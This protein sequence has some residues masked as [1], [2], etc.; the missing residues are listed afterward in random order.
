MTDYIK[1]A[2]ALADGWF[3]ETHGTNPS[4]NYIRSLSGYR[5][6][7]GSADEIID[8]LAAALVRQ[9]DALGYHYAVVTFSD[10]SCVEYWEGGTSEFVGFEEGKD[11]TMNT[12]KCIVDSGVL[13]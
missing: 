5:T 4:S 10:H 3:L 7:I 1:A 11:R 12:L 9:V 8:A 13:T 2:V 6:T